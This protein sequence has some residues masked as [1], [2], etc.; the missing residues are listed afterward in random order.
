M[1]NVYV[2]VLVHFYIHITKIF[3]FYLEKN[4]FDSFDFLFERER[5]GDLKERRKCKTVSSVEVLYIVDRL[6]WT[7]LIVSVKDFSFY[8]DVI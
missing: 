3:Y 7:L 8:A 4:Y 1:K 2:P 5:E 6:R